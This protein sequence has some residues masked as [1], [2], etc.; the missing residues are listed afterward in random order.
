[1]SVREE[2]EM[3]G[4]GRMRENNIPPAGTHPDGH[5]TDIGLD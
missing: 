1:M 3:S 2:R 5:H 4:G